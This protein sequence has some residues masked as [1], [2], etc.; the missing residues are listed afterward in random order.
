MHVCMC[1]GV[2][3]WAVLA[4]A[5]AS[6]GERKG[7]TVEGKGKSRQAEAWNSQPLFGKCLR[8][9][10]ASGVWAVGDLWARRL[11]R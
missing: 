5:G 1:A 9:I 11:P 10:S 3:V 4:G 7:V 8:H 6:I 2:C